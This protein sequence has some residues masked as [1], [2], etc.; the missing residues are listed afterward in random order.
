MD[1]RSIVLSVL[2]VLLLFVV[3]VQVHLRFDVRQAQVLRFRAL[4]VA[5]VDALLE[6]PIGSHQHPHVRVSVIDPPRTDP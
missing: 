1:V 4:G 6:A 3:R 2:L 5:V